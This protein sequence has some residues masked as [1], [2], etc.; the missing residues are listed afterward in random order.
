MQFYAAHNFCQHTFYVPIRMWAWCDAIGV[1]TR[2]LK[3]QTKSISIQRLNQQIVSKTLNQSYMHSSLSYFP[4]T[5]L[6]LFQKVAKWKMT[7]CLHSPTNTAVMLGSVQRII[8]PLSITFFFVSQLS[9]FR[10]SNLFKQLLCLI[11]WMA[12]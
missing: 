7:S 9:S 11:I 4:A 10:V 5:R 12:V 1:V 2:A 3:I 6:Y 8:C